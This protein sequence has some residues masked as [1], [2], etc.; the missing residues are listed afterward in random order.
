MYSNQPTEGEKKSPGHNLVDQRN[1]DN[2][3]QMIGNSENPT[4]QVQEKKIK[5]KLQVIY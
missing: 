4:N 1:M 2:V 3:L 5:K